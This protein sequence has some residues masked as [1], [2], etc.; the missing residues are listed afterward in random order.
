[1][2][3]GTKMHKSKKKLTKV[4]NVYK[5]LSFNKGGG[6]GGWGDSFSKPSFYYFYRHHYHES[7]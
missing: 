2:H 6:G 1:M 3:H 7:I 4:M 5:L